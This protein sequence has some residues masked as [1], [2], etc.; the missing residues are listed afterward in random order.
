MHLCSL[1]GNRDLARF[2][3]FIGI[4]FTSGKVEMAALL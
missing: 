1:S 4:D 3:E 2:W